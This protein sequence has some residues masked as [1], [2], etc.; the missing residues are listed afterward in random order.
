MKYTWVD[1]FVSQL[2][3]DLSKLIQVLPNISESQILVD[4]LLRQKLR[5][6]F[7]VNNSPASMIQQKID[8]VHVK[9]NGGDFGLIVI[10]HQAAVHVFF[11]EN[12]DQFGEF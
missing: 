4:L 6:F 5:R 7:E 2:G 3:I 10:K 1:D 9:E 11:L 12:V 8:E